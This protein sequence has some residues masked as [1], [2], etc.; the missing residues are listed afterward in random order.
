MAATYYVPGTD[1]PWDEA[2]KGATHAL[3][4]DRLEKWYFWRVVKG[5]THYWR[6]NQWVTH[7]NQIDSQNKFQRAAIPKPTEEER[8]TGMNL[9]NAAL[10]VRDDIKTVEVIF[11]GAGRHYT[12][13]VHNSVEVKEG[14]YVLVIANG[15]PNFAEVADIHDQPQIDPNS[16]I[17][18][19]WV[20]S[21]VTQ[22]LTTIEGL[23][24]T[25]DL[26]V[27]KLQQ[28]QARSVREQVLAQFGVNSVQDLL[29]LPEA[30]SSQ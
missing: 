8:S 24:K 7:S 4:S 23:N 25:T 11:S 22:Q 6:Y 21:N 19:Q 18:Y 20:I 2:P 30:I 15:E 16:N 9:R 10:L 26:I 29:G 1:I 28:Q 3:W 13:L 14:D 17:K 27:E 5:V 12:Y